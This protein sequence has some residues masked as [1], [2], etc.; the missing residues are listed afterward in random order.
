[1]AKRNLL[2]A[3][4]W[5]MHKTPDES[6]EEASKIVSML[7][8]SDFKDKE[9]MIAP[10]FTGLYSTGKALKN[11][12]I[13]LGAQNM[14]YEEKGA[15][16][17]EI[18]PSML[19]GCGCSYVIIGHSERRQIFNETDELINKKISAAISN[20]LTPVFC[21]GETKSE[22][23]E[24]KT[25][26]VLDK[27]IKNGLKGISVSGSNELVIAYEPVWAIGTGDTATPDQVEKVHK[28]IRGLIEKI[29]NKNVAENIKI[30][31][32]GSVKSGNAAELLSLDNVDGALV[33]GASLDAKDFTE[34]IK[35]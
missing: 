26:N 24:N 30:L 10:S 34:I 14:F 12:K 7:E 20:S 11:T 3:G 8:D 28:N 29:Y 1:M 21:V 4:N 15:Y 19:K 27:Q 31:Y 33:G 22:R 5:K 2:V 17:G 35:A 9:V 32:G 23:N 6:A 16:T 25:I 13:T 18:S